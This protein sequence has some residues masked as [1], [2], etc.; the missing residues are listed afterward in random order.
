MY[1][2]D[3]SGCKKSIDSLLQYDPK[4][5]YRELSNEIGI[6]AQGIREVKGNNALDFVQISTIPRNKKVSYVNIVYD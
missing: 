2:F 4:I 1:V 6:S 3:N 5:W